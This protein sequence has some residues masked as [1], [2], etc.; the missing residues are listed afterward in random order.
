MLGYSYRNGIPWWEM[1]LT[2]SSKLMP[3]TRWLLVGLLVV[4]APA[5]ELKSDTATA[6]DRYI[7]ATEAQHDEDLRRTHFLIIEGLPEA[8]RRA[9][10]RQTGNVPKPEPLRN[11]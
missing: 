7:R 11:P 10:L 9:R 8:S 3:L 1:Q 4:P 2:R 6:F 5:A